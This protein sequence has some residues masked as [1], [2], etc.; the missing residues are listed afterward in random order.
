MG[1]EQGKCAS[2]QGEGY[3]GTS[4]EGGANKN[5]PAGSRLWQDIE[6]GGNQGNGSVSASES[7][8]SR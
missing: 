6:G 5:V 7:S 2:M 1:R 3:G 4:G 8:V